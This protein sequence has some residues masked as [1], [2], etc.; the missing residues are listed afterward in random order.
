MSADSELPPGCALHAAPQR[1]WDK[2]IWVLVT[3]TK[4]TY[5][6]KDPEDPNKK[7]EIRKPEITRLID[8]FFLAADSP[9]PIDRRHS[10]LL[11]FRSKELRR[12]ECRRKDIVARG[13]IWYIERD[14]KAEE[15]IAVG[16]FPANM[17]PVSVE[18]DDQTGLDWSSCLIHVNGTL[19]GGPF[20]EVRCAWGSVLQVSQ[21]ILHRTTDI[22]SIQ[23]HAAIHGGVFPVDWW[24][25]EQDELPDELL[26]PTMPL[27]WSRHPDGTPWPVFVTGDISDEAINVFLDNANLSPLDPTHR[28]RARVVDMP[29]GHPDAFVFID[30]SPVP[31]LARCFR[32]LSHAAICDFLRRKAYGDIACTNFVILDKLASP[33][34]KP[35]LANSP[36]PDDITIFRGRQWSCVLGDVCDRELHGLVMTHC[37]FDS[38]AEVIDQVSDV[39]ALSSF[40][41]DAAILSDGCFRYSMDRVNYDRKRREKEEEQALYSRPARRKSKPRVEP[42]ALPQVPPVVVCQGASKTAPPLPRPATPTETTERKK[43]RKRRRK[44]HRNSD[45]SS[46][47][48]STDS[49]PVALPNRPPAKSSVLRPSFPGRSFV[50][51]LSRDVEYEPLFTQSHALGLESH[52]ESEAVASVTPRHSMLA[53]STQLFG[54]KQTQG[55]YDYGDDDDEGGS[56]ATEVDDDGDGASVH[57]TEIDEDDDDYGELDVDVPEQSFHAPASQWYDVRLPPATGLTQM[58]GD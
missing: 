57:D 34:A 10:A 5:F 15:P 55:E 48:S 32:G 29:A 24:Y 13:G 8:D 9:L 41:N 4:L 12:Y 1:I 44:R 39:D 3:I 54:L 17:W 26:R 25:P 51:S 6:I 22:A 49:S 47:S 33:T 19:H 11:F 31:P 27:T 23:S 43:K 30:Q 14:G 38:C 36:N 40:A 46:S 52:E 2:L 58:S 16:E 28:L 42:L 20:G 37:A 35:G 7:K 18:L 50:R 45:I 56:Q 21:G 53:S